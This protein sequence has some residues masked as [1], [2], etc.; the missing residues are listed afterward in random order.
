MGLSRNMCRA[1]DTQAICR[2]LAIEMNDKQQVYERVLRDL[3]ELIAE[4]TD[5]I[6]VMATV[7]CELHRRF[8]HFDWTGF[9]R[10]VAPGLLKVG[11]YQGPHGCLQIPFDRGVCGAA[12]RLGRTQIVPDVRAFPGYIA[13]SGATRSEIVVPVFD[14]QEQLL[15]VLDIDSDQLDAFDEIDRV[16][17]EKACQ[18]VGSAG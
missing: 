12:A 6:A 2:R 7:V 13:C 3:R 10:V 14:Q 17:L 16:H 4:E 8:D 15:A 11:P 9:Y 18:M 5:R 1:F